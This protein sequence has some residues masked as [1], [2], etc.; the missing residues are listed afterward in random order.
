MLVNFNKK[1]Y[2]C[3]RY[4]F[5]LRTTMFLLTELQDLGHATRSKS[6]TSTSYKNALW[7]NWISWISASLTKLLESGERDFKLCGCRR[8]TVWTFV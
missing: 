8:R 3:V 5:F 2:H 1:L 4:E 6:K 7:M